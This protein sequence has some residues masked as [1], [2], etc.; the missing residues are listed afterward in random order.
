MEKLI[1]SDNKT[2][3][4]RPGKEGSLDVIGEQPQKQEDIFNRPHVSKVIP[5][6]RDLR[7]KR[8][9]VNTGSVRG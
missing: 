6:L 5:I 1:K 8:E 9:R 3:R 4:F 2:Y 7:K